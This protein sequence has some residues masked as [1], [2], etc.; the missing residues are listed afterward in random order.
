MASGTGGKSRRED[1]E[2]QFCVIEKVLTRLSRVS[3]R[4]VFGGQGRRDELGVDVSDDED[5]TWGEGLANGRC[6][7]LVGDKKNKAR[8]ESRRGHG[9]RGEREKKKIRGTSCFNAPF[10]QRAPR[11]F[12]PWLEVGGRSVGRAATVSLRRMFEVSCWEGK[13][14]EAR[15]PST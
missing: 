5:R 14:V 2:E 12:G 4:V 1:G 3:A 7:S 10:R 6:P 15:S 8:N 11:V 13:R 9:G